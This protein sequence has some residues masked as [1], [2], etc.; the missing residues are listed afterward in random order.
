MIR[1]TD[2]NVSVNLTIMPTMFIL[3]CAIGHCTSTGGYDL[4]SADWANS[5]PTT[6]SWAIFVYGI[7]FADGAAVIGFII[8]HENIISKILRS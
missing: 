6:A 8:K 4:C 5:S 3:A 1:M 7:W 2:Y